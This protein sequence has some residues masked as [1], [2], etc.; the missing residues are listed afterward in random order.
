MYKVIASLVLFI[1]CTGFG[2][3]QK[4]KALAI[5][6]GNVK[7][8]IN[9]YFT[10]TIVV[11]DIMDGIEQSPRQV[12]LTAK[13]QHAIRENYEW[14][15]TYMKTVPAGEPMPY[16]SNMG[17]SKDEY[18]EFQGFM[19]NARLTST[20]RENLEILKKDT[21]ISFKGS[22]KLQPYNEIRID[23]K[24]NKVL[25]KDYVLPFGKEVIIESEDNGFGN[26]WKGYTWTYE[27][28]DGMN[29]ADFTNLE[30][31]NIKQLK[32]TIGQM[33]N[34]GRILLELKERIVKNGIKTKDIGIPILF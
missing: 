4:E 34:D 28:P 1:S 6:T 15:V 24:N 27:Y 33:E 16:H 13:F 10:D 2:Y 11:A 25:Y 23:L 3:S 20:G 32:F 12:E 30:N 9:R 14:F 26:R 17:I 22:G 7:T 21:L 31:L 29:N 19:Q 18:D 5:F 8:D